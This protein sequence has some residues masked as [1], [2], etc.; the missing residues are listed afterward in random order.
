MYPNLF[1]AIKDW[2]GV[3]VNALKIFYTFGI[4]MALAFIAAAF[5]LNKEL[6]RKEK[7]GLLLPREELITVGKP[8]SLMELLMSGII[9]FVFGY[10]LVGAYLATRS[11]S[12]DLQ[13]YIFSLDG[14]LIGGLAL[15]AIMLYLKYREK[16]KQ[17][18]PKPEQRVIRIWPHD[19]VG[20]IL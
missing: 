18:L 15:A 7:Q 4:F 14:S 1:Y 13:Q 17:K 12:V 5:F 3:E 10:K 8:A 2:F 11:A 9:G 19:R 16:S 6:K 20:D